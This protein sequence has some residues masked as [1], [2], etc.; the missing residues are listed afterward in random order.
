[1]RLSCSALRNCG[2]LPVIPGRHDCGETA[3]GWAGH[4][5][6]LEQAQHV[7]YDRLFARMDSSLCRSLSIC[8]CADDG[9]DCQHAMY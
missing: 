8:R 2:M 3:G 4:K 9:E 5:V 7:H 6:E 1:M